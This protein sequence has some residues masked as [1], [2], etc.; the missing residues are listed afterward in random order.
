MNDQPENV[1]AAV[2]AGEKASADV[3]FRMSCDP[4]TGALLRTLAASKPGGR[5][6]E[7]GTGTGVGAGWLLAGMDADAQLVSVERNP[8]NAT[9]ARKLHDDPRLEVVEADA[10]DWLLGYT[11][12]PFDLAFVDCRPGKFEC[13]HLLLQHLAPGALYV[14]D[15]LMPQPTWPD[16]HPPRVSHFLGEIIQEPDLVVTLMRWSSGLVVAAYR[17][18]ARTLTA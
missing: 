18:P 13:R 2:R 10:R 9:I 1:P 15:D 12:R 3:G 6:L 16:D 8:Q 14:G 5:L 7:L 17:G 11:G 4:R